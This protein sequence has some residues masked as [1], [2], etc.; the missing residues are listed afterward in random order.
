MRNLQL[1]NGQHQSPCIS[2]PRWCPRSMD[3]IHLPKAIAEK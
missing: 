3:N 1:K 2:L